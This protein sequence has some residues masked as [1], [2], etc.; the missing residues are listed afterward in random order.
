MGFEAVKSGRLSI[1]SAGLGHE[2]KFA[3][4]NV[5]RGF[6]QEEVFGLAQELREIHDAALITLSANGNG[7]PTQ[8]QI[9]RVMM[10]DDRLQTVTSTQKDFTLLRWHQGF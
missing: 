7:S 3:V 5:W 4:P 9:L 6:S 1:G 8:L 10:S 2:V